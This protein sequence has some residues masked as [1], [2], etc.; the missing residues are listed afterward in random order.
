[1]LD[2]LKSETGCNIFVS[3]NGRVHIKCSEPAMEPILVLA[4]KMIE[5]QAHLSGLTDRVKKYIEEL[6]IV[7]GVSGG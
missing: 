3:V 7:R 5:S 6:K 2:M 4:L 1:M